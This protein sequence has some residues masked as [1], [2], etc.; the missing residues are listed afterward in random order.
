MIRRHGRKNIFYGHK[1]CFVLHET[2]KIRRGEGS[3]KSMRS[4][5][6]IENE[7]R[8]DNKYRQTV[9]PITTETSVKIPFCSMNF[10]LPD[11][12]HVF[13]LISFYFS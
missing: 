1:A 13:L 7:T 11:C 8:T 2:S 9:M 6:K 10:V 12:Y 4:K 3:D 5:R